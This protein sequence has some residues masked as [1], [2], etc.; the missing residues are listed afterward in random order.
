MPPISDR[1]RH[2]RYEVQIPVTLV[3]ADQSSASFTA[4]MRDLSAGGCF[5]RASLPGVDFSSV[6]LSFRRALRAPQVAG[7][8]VRRQEGEGF[9]VQFDDAGPELER[10]V[11]A[12]GALTPTLRGDFVSRFLE[13]AVEIS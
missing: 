8:V 2:P 9:A 13:P 3:V 12:L 1:R 5:F 7:H 10:L 11:S 6:S 4:S